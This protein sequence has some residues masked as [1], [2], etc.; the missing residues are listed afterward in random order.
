MGTARCDGGAVPCGLATGRVR[1]PTT[2][3]GLRPTGERCGLPAWRRASGGAIP[4]RGVEDGDLENAG[5]D[6]TRS[7]ARAVGARRAVLYRV[8]HVRRGGP[9]DGAVAATA[10]VQGCQKHRRGLTGGFPVPRSAALLRLPV[11]LQR[12]GREGGPGTAPARLSEDDA[13]HVWA[14]V[15][16]LG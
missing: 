15:A 12:T 1:G 11:D 10:G 8:G 4:G 2:G 3:R 13:G 16:G 5:A 9:A 6:P 7:G 14:P